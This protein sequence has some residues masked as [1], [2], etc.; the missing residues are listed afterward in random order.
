VAIDATNNLVRDETRA[1]SG[2]RKKTWA[3]VGVHD[4]VIVETDDAVLVIPRSQAQDVRAVVDALRERGE[5]DK[6]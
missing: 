5:I 3:L 4:L 1:R 6:L 2:P